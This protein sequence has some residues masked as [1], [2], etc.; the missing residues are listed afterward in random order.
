MDGCVSWVHSWQVLKWHAQV[1]LKRRHWL[2]GGWLWLW[3]AWLEVNEVLLQ[4]L[5]RCIDLLRPVRR[6]CWCWYRR[7]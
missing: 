5:P 6:L 4:L 3:L 7:E 2:Y 1:L